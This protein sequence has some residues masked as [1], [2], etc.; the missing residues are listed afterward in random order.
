MKKTI[1]IILILLV[2]IMLNGEKLT[3]L[4]EISKPGLMEIADGKLYIMEGA[5]IFSYDLKSKKLVKRFGKNGEGP[6]EL[7]TNPGVPN[8][9]IVL[10]NSILAVS[11]DKA[12]EFSYNGKLIKETKIPGLTNYLYPI[13][14]GYISMKTDV[15]SGKDA[16]SNIMLL[17]KEL[18]KIK[19][20]YSQ[21]LS[22][23]NNLIDLTLDG[24]NIAVDN[25]K[26]Y[27]EESAKGFEISVFELDGTPVK[28]ITKNVPKIEF[29]DKYRE[30]AINNLKNNSAIKQ[31]GWENFKSRVK[32]INQKYLPLIQD[33]VVDNKKLYIKSNKTKDST[34]EFIVLDN[35]GKELKRVFL[36]KPME[37]NFVSKMFGRP[38]RF[39]KFYN[40]TYYYIIEN[41]EDEEW[42]L[43]SIKI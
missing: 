21:D 30:E 25:K 26:L 3:T 35:S 13:K 10:E 17:D 9:L 6:G 40:D 34:V 23:G 19:T 37:A 12:I 8:Y 2:S 42:E 24:I 28:R 5:T 31:M 18:K 15:G 27:I 43:H 22:G 4:N 33:M 38:A 39:Y 16:K 7:K 1:Y 32:I 11:M 29:S 20:L 41:E 14:S 36:P